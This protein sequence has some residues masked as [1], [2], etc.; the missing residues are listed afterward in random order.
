MPTHG[1]YRA[2]NLV[3]VGLGVLGYVRQQGWQEVGTGEIRRF[4]A[5]GDA[6]TLARCAV[7]DPGDPGAVGQ[8]DE[9]AEIGVR[10]PRVADDDLAHHLRHPGDEV[11]VEVRRH[12]RTGRRR[13]V[14]AR[15]DQ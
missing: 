2:E 4:A 9:R 1:Q 10:I 11:V 6:P 3:A 15:V 5:A 12:D 7:D 8:R 13:A 14:L